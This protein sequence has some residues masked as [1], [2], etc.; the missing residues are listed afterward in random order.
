L[1]DFFKLDATFATRVFDL[2]FLGLGPD[3]HTASLFPDGRVSGWANPWVIAP[4]VEHLAQ[5]R[6]SMTS[7]MLSCS[8]KIVFLVSG[9]SKTK[10]LQQALRGP[11]GG[12]PAGKIRAEFGELVW[13]VDRKAFSRIKRVA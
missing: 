9:A 13:L 7:L 4:W 2:N 10:A 5:F 6:V 8:A 3:G 11:G 1:K 12:V